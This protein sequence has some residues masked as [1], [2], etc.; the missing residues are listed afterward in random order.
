MPLDRRAGA[1]SVVDLLA[2]HWRSRGKRLPL[3]VHRIDRDTSGLVIF[4]A[5]PRAQ[6]H[7]KRQFL[8]REPERIY[9]AVLHGRLRPEAGEW[10]DRL[11]WNERALIQRKARPA[12][13]RRRSTPSAPTACW[14]RSTPRRV[15][16]VRLDTGKQNQIRIQAQLHGHPLVGERRYVDEEVR[17]HGVAFARQALHAFRLSFRHPADDRVLRFEA[18]LPADLR[19][20]LARLTGSSAGNEP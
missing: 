1:D 12:D 9:W 16:E 7:L 13:P 10:R 15:V 3:V 5:N 19:K 6:Q 8:R 14:R 20:L 2:L 18:P 11:V 4:A 17:R